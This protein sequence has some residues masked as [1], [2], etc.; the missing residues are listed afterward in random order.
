MNK[1]C[2]GQ[3]REKFFTPLKSGAQN[4]RRRKKGYF[5]RRRLAT[6]PPKPNSVPITIMPGSGNVGRLGHSKP[7]CFGDP[8]RRETP[9]SHDAMHRASMGASELQRNWPEMRI[10]TQ[11]A[12]EWKVE[13]R[14]VLRTGQEP[15]N[16]QI[17]WET[18]T[19]TPRATRNTTRADFIA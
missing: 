7:Q 12:R 2:S 17:P 3:A 8:A 19:S 4:E 1:L 14:A 16:L 18:R 10:S 5:F 15:N 13:S 9:A 6:N 11:Q